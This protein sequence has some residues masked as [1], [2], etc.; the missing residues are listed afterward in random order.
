MQYILDPANGVIT[1]AIIEAA[2]NKGKRPD[3]RAILDAPEDEYRAYEQSILQKLQDK[4]WKPALHDKVLL[5]EGSHK[6]QRIIEKPRFDELV[7]QH[8]LM[9]PFRPIFLKRAYKYSLGSIPG[10]G[11]KQALDAVTKWLKGYKEDKPLYIAELDIRKF[12]ENVDLD[13]L[14]AKLG[15]LI[16]D[17]EYLDL[18]FRSLDNRGPGLPLGYYTSPWLGNFYLTSLD[19]Y[20]LQDLKPDHYLR[21]LDNMFLFSQDKEELHEMVK[22]ITKYTESELHVKIKEDWQVFR[23]EYFDQDAHCYRGRPINLLGYVVHCDRI[24]IRKL[25]LKRIRRK[26]LKV[27]RTKRFYICDARTMMSYRGYFINSNTYNYYVKYI[28][29][30]CSFYKCLH[31]ILSYNSRALDGSY[32]PLTLTERKKLTQKKKQRGRYYP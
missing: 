31:K 13:I 21:Y 27:K 24:G 23:F 2:Q 28:R 3:I 1:T 11:P 14:K 12:Y 26:A 7:I 29:P 20:I 9:I 25:I 6:K 19:N 16:R 22:C 4:N 15:K 10:G 18:L 17:K 30:Y 5:R 32:R 8:C